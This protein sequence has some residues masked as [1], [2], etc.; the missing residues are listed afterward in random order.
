MT[1]EYASDYAASKHAV[2]G[3]AKSQALECAADG[4]RVNV[5]CPGFFKPDM[6][7][8]HYGVATAQLTGSV[9][10]A[11]RIGEQGVDAVVDG[12]QE[13]SGRLGPGPLGRACVL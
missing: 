1:F 5:L 9:I 8:E 11:A 4:I 2:V 12:R 13:R 6:Y 3:M 10:P 7:D